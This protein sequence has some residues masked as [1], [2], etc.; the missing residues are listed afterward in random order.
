MLIADCPGINDAPL[1][2][3]AVREG[4]Q[5]VAV[6]DVKVEVEAVPLG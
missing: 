4:G 5:L 6:T 3:A 1:K 2:G